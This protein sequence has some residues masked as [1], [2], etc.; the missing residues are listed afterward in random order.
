MTEG[1]AN[2]AEVPVSQPSGHA[3]K[4]GMVV[5]ATHRTS[6]VAPY[7]MPGRA[8]P[9]LTAKKFPRLKQ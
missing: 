3:A 8:S 7:G 5:G 9:G 6:A 2:T 1:G 4:A